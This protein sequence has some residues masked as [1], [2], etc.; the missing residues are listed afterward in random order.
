MAKTIRI[1]KKGGGKSQNVTFNFICFDVIRHIILSIIF[2]SMTQGL[3]QFIFYFNLFLTNFLFL[4]PLKTSAGAFLG[5]K[6][7]T[8][9]RNK[10]INI[11]KSISP[12][13]NKL[14]SEK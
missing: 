9:A 3:L 6:M 14:G 11:I 2:I 10:I 4:Y 1:H 5:Y 12:W 7:G 8:I 13:Y